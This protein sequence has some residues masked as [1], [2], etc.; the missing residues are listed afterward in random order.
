MQQKTRIVILGGGAGGLELAALLAGRKDLHVTLV[1]MVSSHLWKPRLHEFAAGTVS[2]SL[3]EISFYILGQ[4]R[5]FH[6]EQGEVIGIDTQDRLVRL[7]AIR[8]PSKNNE[9]GEVLAGERTLP[10]D[11]CVVA[12]GGVTPDF[13]TPGVAEN[14]IRLDGQ[15]DAEYFRQHFIA[16]M[17]RARATGVPADVV[18]IGS[19]ATG[20]ELAAHLRHS[21]RAFAHDDKPEQKL[22]NITVLEAAPEIMPGA[23]ESL[24]RELVQR[25]ALLDIKVVTDARISEMQ[26][27]EI[28]TA[29]GEKWPFD[30]AV[31]A[32][33]LVGNPVLKTLG[34]FECDGSGRIKVDAF[35][36]STISDRVFVIGDS[37]SFVPAGAE[38]PL[39]PTAQAASQQAHYLADSLIRHLNGKLVEPFRYKH[40]GR[41]VSLAQ[42]GVV[43]TIGRARKRDLLIQGQFAIAAYDALQRQHQW[44]VLG[45][46]RGSVAI[47]ADLM[48]PTHG[49]PLKL[50]GG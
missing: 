14:A 41:L 7:D 5:G 4:L 39:P 12:L 16:E 21:E 20:T 47:A 45:P 22:L 48:S 13:N 31:W 15:P 2:S 1:D 36:R 6:F 49:P 27:D 32:A 18:I 37:A 50:H 46:V 9:Q 17:I 23:E 26:S 33:G 38:K 28:K 10:Y 35:L 34:D 3:S 30:I 11:Y 42:A 19:G 8:G 40:K 24:R 43:G 29:T 25:L 44:R